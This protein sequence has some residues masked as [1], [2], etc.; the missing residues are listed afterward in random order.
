MIEPIQHDY[1]LVSQV[2]NLTDK[3]NE[4]IQEINRI[5]KLIEPTSH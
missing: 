1:D 3:I 5:K 2:E 4:L